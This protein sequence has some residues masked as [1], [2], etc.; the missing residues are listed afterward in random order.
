VTIGEVVDAADIEVSSRYG[1]WD[2]DQFAVTPPPGPAPAPGAGDD[3]TG[4]TPG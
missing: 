1:S 3:E 4:L 2:P